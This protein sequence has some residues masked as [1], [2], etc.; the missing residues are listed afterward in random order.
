[1]AATND[2]YT[3]LHHALI[4][5]PGYLELSSK[6]RKE[7]SDFVDLATNLHKNPP[8]DPDDVEAAY[9]AAV[10][11]ARKLVAKGLLT[12]ELPKKSSRAA[13]NRPRE[14]PPPHSRT[15]TTRSIRQPPFS[16]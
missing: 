9:V 15:R 2:K 11:E 3:R 7:C 14:R 13:A 12:V 16:P 1:M 10:D 6:D 4:V 8:P 5:A